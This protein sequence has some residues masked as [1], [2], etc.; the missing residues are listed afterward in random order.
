VQERRYITLDGRIDNALARAKQL[1]HNAI[2]VGD[3]H[4][5]V[6]SASEPGVKYDIW[7]TSSGL[8]CNCKAGHYGKP[9]KHAAK[10]AI[11]LQREGV[12]V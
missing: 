11:R 5:R 12:K 4:Y 2:R 6:Y 1:G 7:V 10:V 3:N 9:C 8:A